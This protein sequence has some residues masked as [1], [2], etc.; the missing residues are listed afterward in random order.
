[1]CLT[2]DSNIAVSQREQAA[3]MEQGI[4]TVRV[5]SMQEAIEKLDKENFLFVAINADTINYLPLLRVMRD[6][7]PIL[8]Y[9]IT[10]NFT[11]KEHKEALD[12]G[13]DA[14]VAFQGSAEENVQTAMAL[15]SRH[16]ERIAMPKKPVKLITYRGLL[17][18]PKYS[19]VFYRDAKIDL[20][21]TEY[22]IFNLLTSNP[23]Q[24]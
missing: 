14:Y 22:D 9:V 21:K 15:I 2:V 8:I 20:T 13:A 10:S 24:A 7:T 19:K 18:Y 11:A 1:M 17:F 4:A 5:D 12:N 6:V 23:N 3:W 16:S